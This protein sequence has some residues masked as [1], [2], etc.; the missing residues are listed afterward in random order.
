V[1]WLC[2]FTVVSLTVF[3]AVPIL[4]DSNDRKMDS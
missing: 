4:C 3:P 2:E 1:E